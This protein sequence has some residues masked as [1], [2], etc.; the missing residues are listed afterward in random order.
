MQRACHTRV[1]SKNEGGVCTLTQLL[2]RGGEAP[3]LR[4]E[5]PQLRAPP[6]PVIYSLTS[7][8]V[9]PHLQNGNFMTYSTESVQGVSETRRAVERRLHPL[10]KSGPYLA[11]ESWPTWGLI[12]GPWPPEHPSLSVFP[13]QHRPVLPST[14]LPIFP[15]PSV[16]EVLGLS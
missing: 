16:E 12:H 10:E 6:P 13:R 11:V 14:A 5:G 9:S 1:N 15:E 3:A 2:G 7:S 4:W 8:L